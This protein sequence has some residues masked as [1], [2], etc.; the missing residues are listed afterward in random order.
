MPA[1]VQGTADRVRMDLS[2]F[3]RDFPT[4]STA[5][6][7]ARYGISPPRV[8]RRGRAL[9]LRKS[10]EYRAQLT[11]ERRAAGKMVPP[12]GADHYNWKGGRPWERFRDPRYLE[13]RAAVLE[14]DGYR[15]QRCGRQCKKYE[16]GLAAHH[17]KP[18]AEYPELR[19]EITNGMTLCR[20]CH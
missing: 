10:T 6:L 2:A 8:A 7:A 12:R 5:L 17:I 3:A 1:D 13:W 20:Q 16:R 18:Y 14:R 11:R 19:Y 9:G 15:C 4:T